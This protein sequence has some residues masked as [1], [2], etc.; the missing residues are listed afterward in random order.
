MLGRSER[1]PERLRELITQ[2]HERFKNIEEGNAIAT[3]TAWLVDQVK[4][5]SD[6]EV[7]EYLLRNSLKGMLG[8][9]RSQVNLALR[10]HVSRPVTAV[11]RPTIRY[12]STEGVRR[13]FRTI[14]PYDYCVGGVVLRNATRAILAKA[15]QRSHEASKGNEYHMRVSDWCCEQL[16]DDYSKVP[17]VISEVELARNMRR[18][19]QEVFGSNSSLPV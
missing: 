4:Q 3:G 11:T 2:A 1:I 13:A 9:Y 5:D 18:I 19:H 10:Q 16:T 8:N 17:D 15:S 7:F 6:S 12:G 14:S